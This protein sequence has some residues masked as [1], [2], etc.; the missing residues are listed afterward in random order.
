MGA[1]QIVSKFAAAGSIA[2]SG[3]WFSSGHPVHVRACVCVCVGSMIYVET[4]LCA[5]HKR[6]NRRAAYLQEKQG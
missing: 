4:E 1:Y 6:N 5:Q 3:L 2:Y